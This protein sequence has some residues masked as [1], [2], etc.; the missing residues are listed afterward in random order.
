MSAWVGVCVCGAW[1]GGL[2]PSVDVEALSSHVVVFLL[3][4]IAS[5]QGKKGDAFYV[6]SK[7]ASTSNVQEEEKRSSY[8]K[9]LAKNE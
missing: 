4:L 8:E 5:E 6:F 7:L 2:A 3:P 1:D 9:E